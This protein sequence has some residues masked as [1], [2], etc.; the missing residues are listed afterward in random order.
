MSTA[1][2]GCLSQRRKDASEG[3]AESTESRAKSHGE[4]V[5]GFEF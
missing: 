2:M 1:D 3:R 5:S 4:R